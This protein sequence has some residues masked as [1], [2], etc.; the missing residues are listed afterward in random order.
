MIL[1]TPVDL[2]RLDQLEGVGP[3]LEVDVEVG[4]QDAVL[5]HRDH[6]LVRVLAQVAQDL[7]VVQDHHALVEVV[8]L[9]DGGGIELSQRVLGLCLKKIMLALPFD[10]T[11]MPSSLETC[12]WCLCG[13]GHGR[14]RQSPSP[15]PVVEKAQNSSRPKKAIL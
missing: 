14:G 2:V 6:L 15:T 3:P 4:G 13:R 1:S 10:S 5:H 8:L 11:L 9:Q 7:V 12:C